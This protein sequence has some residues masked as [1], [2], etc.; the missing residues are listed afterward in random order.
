MKIKK[1]VLTKL[2]CTT[3][4]YLE[5]NT[6]FKHGSLISECRGGDR[7]RFKLCQRAIHSSLIMIENNGY[8]IR[9]SSSKKGAYMKTN[10]VH[11]IVIRTT[12][13]GEIHKV[14]T[15]FTK[16]MGKVTVMAHGAKKT[17]GKLAGVT[18]IFTNGCYLISHG[19]REG[20]GTLKQG[21]TVT[22]YKS[23]QQDI[24][25]TSYA[26]AIIELVDYLA[27]DKEPNPSMFELLEKALELI[28]KGL[29]PQVILSVTETK[30]MSIAGI[31]PNL[32]GCVCCEAH[33]GSFAFSVKEGG[34]I[35][36]Q[37]FDKDRYRIPVSLATI[38]IFRSLYYV[39]LTR[40]E[41]I[42]IKEQTKHEIDT[43]LT[44]LYSEYSGIVLKSKDFIKQMEKLNMV[45]I[46]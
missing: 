34:F 10:T 19:R 32:D 22:R 12:A 17:T 13:Y 23:L 37:C 38:R 27:M 45:Q 14:V 21:E 7:R 46:S 25:R 24:M 29:D 20:M 9:N 4:Y 28:D 42:N 39:D 40:L 8:D 6:F 26:S 30:L 44:H 36:H 11:G 5:S 1:V 15:L 41:N 2:G 3:F 43:I 16:E 18:Q 35:C 33:N 31:H